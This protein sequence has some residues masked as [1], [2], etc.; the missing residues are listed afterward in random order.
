MSID[1][2]MQ[3][4]KAFRCKTNI[5]SDYSK[6]VNILDICLMEGAGTFLFT[7]NLYGPLTSSIS[8]VTKSII[9]SISTYRQTVLFARAD[10]LVRM[11]EASYIYLGAAEKAKSKFEG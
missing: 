2:K 4:F 7:H 6:T 3:R 11:W 5:G 10:W 8:S 1:V 9:I